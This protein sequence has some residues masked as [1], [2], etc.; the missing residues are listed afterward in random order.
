LLSVEPNQGGN[1]GQVTVKL[2]GVGF[3][4][5]DSVALISGTNAA[6]LAF[7]TNVVSDAE[8]WASFDLTQRSAGIYSMRLSLSGFPSTTLSNGFAVIEG[9]G[10]NLQAQFL[11]PSVLRARQSGSFQVQVGNSGLND[12]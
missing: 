7:R 4:N 11:I 6:L 12:A 10:A 3:Q 9:G 1:R 8:I 5:G 2:S